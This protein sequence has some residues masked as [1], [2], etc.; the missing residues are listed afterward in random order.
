MPRKK[1]TRIRYG[2]ESD[3]P[4]AMWCNAC[5]CIRGGLHVIPCP[6]EECPVCGRR[7][8]ACG[9]LAELADS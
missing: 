6:R 1:C 3:K 5:Q 7:G 2:S 8:N 4:R 9:H